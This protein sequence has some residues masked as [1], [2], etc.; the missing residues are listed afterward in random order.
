MYFKTKFQA[1]STEHNDGS[2]HLFLCP[3]HDR[4][5]VESFHAQMIP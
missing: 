1:N 2:K 5:D 4:F 3:S